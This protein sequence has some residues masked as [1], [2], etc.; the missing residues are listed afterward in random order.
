MENYCLCFLVVI[1]ATLASGVA[2]DIPYT[3]FDDE[4]LKAV[5]GLVKGWLNKIFVFRIV[6]EN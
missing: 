6:G 2:P 3:G 5:E 1:E 4:R